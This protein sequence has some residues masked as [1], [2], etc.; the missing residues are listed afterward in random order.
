MPPPALRM[1][2]LVIASGE[3]RSRTIAEG[4]AM[5]TAMDAEFVALPRAGHI[6]SLEEP[7]PVSPPLMRLLERAFGP[8]VEAPHPTW[9]YRALRHGGGH[10]SDR[11]NGAAVDDVFGAGDRRGPLRGKEGD[12]ARHLFRRRRAADRNTAEPVHDDALAAFEVGA[13]LLR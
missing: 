7:D 13:G 2:R 8:S 11:R 6:A 5:A 1:P 10:R 9:F 3:D 4:K 12:Q